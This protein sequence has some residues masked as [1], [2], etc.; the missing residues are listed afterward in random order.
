MTNVS[1]TS[2]P[3]DSRHISHHS[4]IYSVYDNDNTVVAV[5]HDIER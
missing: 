3:S 4:Q 5:P 2:Q 1:V